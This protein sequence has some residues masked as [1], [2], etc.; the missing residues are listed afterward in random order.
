MLARFWM[1]IAAV[2]V[3]TTPVVGDEIK[4][5]SW[6]IENLGET[7]AIGKKH[8]P[9]N[10]T[11]STM[12]KIAEIILK[13]KFDLVAIQEYT[14]KGVEKFVKDELLEEFPDNW[15]SI[16]SS[17]TGCEKYLILYR[18]D[19]V[20]PINPKI[21]IYDD[22]DIKME[23][24]PGYCSFKTTKGD[25][26]FTI[27]TCHNR[28]WKDGAEEDAKFLDDVYKGVQERLGTD[29]N[30][31]ILLGDF[32]IHHDHTDH[33][34]ELTGKGFKN[35]ICFDVDTMRSGSNNSNLDNIFYIKCKDLT[36]GPSLEKDHT[37]LFDDKRISD[38]YPVWAIF[39]IPEVDN[40][41]PEP[42]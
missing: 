42:E 25:F 21:M 15:C 40:D 29:D 6:N 36:L 14:D 19:R 33:F 31:I 26:D 22:W 12:S 3:L 11:K 1:I 32:N 24:L 37:P 16:A 2:M 4:I 34:K 27:I 28:T 9:D 35:A 10:G 39:D 7:K 18:K 13:G 20:T 5:A 23:R 38:H 30:D 41:A 8:N 17:N